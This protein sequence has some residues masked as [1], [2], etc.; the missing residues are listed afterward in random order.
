MA[1]IRGSGRE[2]ARTDEMISDLHWE[3]IAGMLL[4]NRR[5]SLITMLR[6]S[7]CFGSA[8]DKV[9]ILDILAIPR[10]VGA[11]VSDLAS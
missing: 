1:P 8:S 11:H 3:G 4:R 5:A 9:E 6:S 10:P 7:T 2:F